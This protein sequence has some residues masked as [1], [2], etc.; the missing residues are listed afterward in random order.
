MWIAV[1]IA[2]GMGLGL[3]YLAVRY[4]M[5][6]NCI[7]QAGADL[8]DIMDSPQENRILLA[9]TPSREAEQLLRQINRYIEFHQRERIVWQQQER[10][11]QEQ[12]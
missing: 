8:A 6:K 3:L 1:G 9:A 2:V 7:R 5:L 10:Q 11:L 12:I 4:R